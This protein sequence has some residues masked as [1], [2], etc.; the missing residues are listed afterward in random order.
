MDRLVPLTLVRGQA[1]LSDTVYVFDRGIV[2]MKGTIKDG[3][4]LLGLGLG[5]RLGH[6]IRV[7]VRARARFRAQD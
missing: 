6:K 5:L 2:R 1:F 7:R 3:K 4:K